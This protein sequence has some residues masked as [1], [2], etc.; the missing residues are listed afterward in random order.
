MCGGEEAVE[1]G[2][3]GVGVRYLYEVIEDG[4]RYGYDEEEC[5]A[6]SEDDEGRDDAVETLDGH[7]DGARQLRVDDVDVL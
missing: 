2:V 7:L 5:G 6:D 1:V 3:R 4:E